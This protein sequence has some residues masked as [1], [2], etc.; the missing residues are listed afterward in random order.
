MDAKIKFSDIIR[1]VLL[2]VFTLGYIILYAYL[3]DISEIKDALRQ[4][5]GFITQGDASALVLIVMLLGSYL[6]GLI[7]Q[8]VRA[9][10][11]YYP[12]RWLSHNPKENGYKSLKAKIEYSAYSILLFGTIFGECFREKNGRRFNDD[13]PVWL[14][15]TDNPYATFNFVRGRLSREIQEESSSLGESYYYQDLFMGL[16]YSVI[17]V[18][19]VILMFFWGNFTVTAYGLT[20]CLLSYISGI[21][22]LRVAAH[23]Q[24]RSYLRYL[25]SL[26][27]LFDDYHTS[28]HPFFASRL[29]TVYV[30]IRTIEQNGRL[31]YLTRAVKSILDQNYPNKHIIILEDKPADSKREE[32][33]KDESL[34][35]QIEKLL[36]LQNGEKPDYIDDLKKIVT[37]K[38][39][40]KHLGASG[41][42]LDIREHFLSEA[43]KRDIAVFLDDDDYFDRPD[44]LMDIAIRMKSTNADICLTTFRNV[45]DMGCV[46]SNGGGRF[47]NFTV[48]K[49][50]A[51]GKSCA[52][53]HE[54]IFTDTLGW[55]KSYSYGMIRRYIDS[56]RSYENDGLHPGDVRYVETPAFED[57]PDFVC[58][59][60]KG[61]KICAVDRP[62]HCYYNR[63]ESITGGRSADAF[64]YRKNFLG[65]SLGLVNFLQ[66][67]RDEK[68][69]VVSASG[70]EIRD[71]ISY[72]LGVICNIILTKFPNY[73]VK[74]F[75]T[76]MAGDNKTAMS[77]QSALLGSI[78]S[79]A[80]GS[81]LMEAISCFI[82]DKALV[83]DPE[84]LEQYR[85]ELQSALSRAME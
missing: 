35:D 78:I 66:N 2:G 14:Y 37:F 3:L 8:S 64:T 26:Y 56:I 55:T 70:N 4:T 31:G 83:I 15:L 60:F 40:P 74:E 45:S 32:N 42:S 48:K 76:A 61:A 52:Y 67:K 80:D 54:L 58:Y 13:M 10:V 69:A 20:V 7:I 68:T 12:V 71:F 9:I 79:E 29:P 30:L 49:I 81:N 46:L 77:S 50:A 36:Y 57:F 6:I 75:I 44:A 82:S 43:N 73:S 5:I 16:S 24:S 25:N 51:S 17:L 53:S 11:E 18:P 62:T 63:S 65:Y 34:I 59:L 27:N 47:H 41:A 72:K 39:S 1:Y 21:I 23:L 85:H 84:H 33:I 28:R 19:F 38:E 22:F